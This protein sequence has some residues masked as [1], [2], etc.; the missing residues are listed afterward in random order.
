[1]KDRWL[2]VIGIGDDGPDGLIPAA[3]SLL[4]DAEI[5]I[6]ADRHLE[7]IPDDGRER[8]E[9]TSPLTEMA[10]RITDYRGRRVAVLASG[11]PM[12]FGIGSTLTRY[13]PADEMTILPALPSFTL[14]ASRM[15]WP[16]DRCA[17]ITLH[18]RPLDNLALHV[19]PGARLLI[20]SNDGTTPA[21]VA[22]WLTMRGFGESVITALSHMGGM[23]ET[24]HDG[25][26]MNWDHKVPDLNTLAVECVSGPDA[27]WQPRIGGL[28]DDL[29]Q[30]D[31]KMTKREVRAAALAKL[32]P[33]PGALLWDIGAGCGSV[34]IEWMRAADLSKAI[35]LEPRA[36]RRDFTAQNAVTLGVPDLDI[37]DGTAP[38]A[39]TDLPEPDAVFVGGGISDQTLTASVAALKP[40][41]R[42]VAHAVTLE[43]EVCL[44]EAQGRLGGELTRISIA[45][46]EPVG[47]RRG[48]RQAMPVTQWSLEKARS[49]EP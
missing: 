5:I 1:M 16:F 38:E 39:L 20:L 22:D 17:R 4:D 15:A 14:A 25:T 32:K 40:G 37:R 13:L 45:R 24:R 28:A 41:G 43:S 47:N 27:E 2:S 19:H 33:H 12:C 10:S 6:G 23:A 48:W 44:I 11:D 8:L 7:K 36:D 42:L 46:A 35:A 18:G 29:F 34:S 26:A 49:S 9:W 3:R 21:D 31:G 30:N